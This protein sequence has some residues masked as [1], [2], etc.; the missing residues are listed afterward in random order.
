MYKNLVWLISLL[1]GCYAHS[2]TNNI[3][4]QMKETTS[5]HTEIGIVK[6][7]DTDNGLLVE[8]SLKN[9]SPGE[10]GFHIHEY[11][12]C[13]AGYDSNGN[14]I[15]AQK[16]G[17]HFD[18]EKTG[19]HLGPHSH[20]HKGDLLALHATSDGTVEVK[21]YRPNLTLNEIKNR[22]LIIHEGGDNYMDIPLPLGGGG[23]R[24]ACGIIK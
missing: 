8:A 23:K 20:G 3:S 17:G 7:H 1:S 14:L 10:H 22:S 24:I 2:D 11:P 16:A 15:P 18:P 21:F 19:K 12:N 9:L 13:N 4:V 5:P 6:L